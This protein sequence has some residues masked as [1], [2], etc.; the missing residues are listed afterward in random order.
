MINK[1]NVFAPQPQSKIPEWNNPKIVEQNK[2]R[3]HAHFFGYPNLPLA[4]VA[5]PQQAPNYQSLNGTWKFHWSPKP[6][7]Q[8]I[9]FYKNDFN[10][11]E[12]AD[13]PVPSN[14]EL[15]GHGVPIY[16]NIAYEFTNKPQP[17]QI[18]TDYNSVGSYKRTF[19]IPKNWNEQQIFIHFGAVKSGFYLWVNG[20]KV[21][22]SQGSKLPAEF[23]ITDFVKIGTNTV[24]IEV[25][26]WTDGSWLECQDFWRI[27]GIERDVYIYSTPKV[28]VLDFFAQTDLSDDFK[29]GLFQLEIELQKYQRPINN[30]FSVSYQILD[31]GK[32]ILEDSKN[33]H[34]SI[35][36]FENQIPNIQ[37]WTAET[38]YLYQLLIE[39]KDFSGKTLQI[40][41]FKIGFRKIEIKNG[42]F[43]INGKAILIKGVNRHEHDPKTGHV[44]SEASMIKDIQLMKQHNINAVR[45]AHYPND[46]R[47]Y[48]LC[49]EYGLYVVDEA[50]IE[51]HA[52]G[53]RLDQTLANQPI[54]KTAHLQRTIRMVERDKN[55]P[56]IITWS[57]GNE[58]G[59]GVNMYATY[60]WIKQRDPSRPIQYERAIVDYNGHV[61]WNTDI[62]APMYAWTDQMQRFIKNN[63]N[64][65][66]IQCEYAHAMGNSVGNLPEYWEV[67]RANPQMQ[68]GYI[69]DWVDQALYKTLDDGTQI[70]AYGGDWGDENTPS[71]DNFCINGLILPNREINPHLLE[72]KQVYQDIH[73]EMID[74]SEQTFSIYNEYFFK[75]LDD[76][77]L[78]WQVLEDGQIANNGIIKDLKIE[79][80]S[81]KILPIPFQINKKTAKD[82]HLNFYFKTKEKTILLEKGHILAQAQIPLKEDYF[83][84]PQPIS[85]NALILTKEKN[86]LLITGKGFKI[87]FN[88]PNLEL[89]SYQKNG[90]E[91]IHAPLQPNFWR[92]PTD[93]DYGARLPQKLQ[94]WKNPYESFQLTN[95]QVIQ[96]DENTIQIEI[97]GKMLKGKID[98]MLQYY[99]YGSG[100]IKVTMQIDPNQTPLPMLPRFGMQMALKKNLDKMKWF[101]RGPHESY[102]DRKSSAFVGMYQGK[103]S[104][105]FHPYIRPQE[106]ANKTDVRWASFTDQQANGLLFKAEQNM[107]ISAY[108]YYQNDLDGGLKKAQTHAATL[109]K[110]DFTTINIDLQQMGIGGNNS[111]G[112]TALKKYQLPCQPYRFSFCIQLNE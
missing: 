36:K 108:H 34:S 100:E 24:A 28:R 35:F 86:Q 31:Q 79:P 26:R 16:V 2:E 1:M 81:R 19:N 68:G 69:W 27:S 23:D 20:K 40:I 43:L 82:I 11:S 5:Q 102:S 65:P 107:N 70:M 7:D 95:N 15:E 90:Q 103:V 61:E 109:P 97:K 8:P 87:K 4:Q 106:T 12:W 29:N 77:L 76:C 58:A 92:P 101:G 6:A 18:P 38:P 93:N 48:E 37:P 47:W 49:D 54:F 51:S 66:L 41:P 74:A 73:I 46:S 105:Q 94:V 62:I 96:I 91:Y 22:Y 110:R 57:L 53:Y 85:S 84:I 13:I 3:P 59:N 98:L 39:L 45:T 60:D 21:G 9:D 63:P 33:G 10:T 17:H 30:N 72:V 78:E 67:I 112:A 52:I 14:W 83:L 80:Q 42:Q 44:I 32:I 89:I 71:D 50:N 99:I 56:C 104:E 88:Q 111:W 55:H 75:N 64:R 25:Y